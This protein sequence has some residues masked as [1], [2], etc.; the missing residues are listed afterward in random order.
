MALMNS[1]DLG[2]RI[3]NEDYDRL[4][5]FYGHDTGAL[6]AYVK[7]LINRLVP[8]SD[9]IM[10]LHRFDGKK[11]DIAEFANA[12][13]A[14]P[15][16]SDRVCVA[17]NDLNMEAVAK[18]DGDDIRRILSELPETTVVVIYSTGVDL[19]KNKRYLT[20]KN[21]RFC[22]FCGKIGSCCEFSYKRPNEL[23][24]SIVERIC[25]SGGAISRYNAEYLANMCL[26]DTSFINLELEKLTSYAT[27]REITKEDIDALCVKHVES[28]GFSL[29]LNILKGNAAMVFA[30][31]SELAD[32]NYEAF[33]ILGVIGFSISDIYRAKLARA[34]G[35]MYT[36]PVKD[37]KYPKNREF[38]VKNAYSE[39]ANISLERIRKTMEILSDTDLTLK[40]KSSGSAGDMLIL[41]QCATKAMA[42]RC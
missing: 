10:N 18:S 21:K 26:C 42:L 27:G 24:K 25:K 1:D 20:D 16:F 35:K 8:A 30:R 31:L 7:K 3:R 13:E 19:Y 41:E 9:Q 5:Y 33:E 15:L 2:K 4:Y 14:L 36:D 39:C 28:D 37:F 11:I 17:V 6:E 32:Q 38:A 34:S 29:A 40:T 12:C 23:A 22:D